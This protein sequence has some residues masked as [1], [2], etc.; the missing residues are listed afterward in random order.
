MAKNET[1]TMSMR[2]IDRLKVIQAVVDRNLKPMQAA[3]RLGLTTRQVRRMVSRYRDDGPA[4]RNRRC[5][6]NKGW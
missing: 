6:T 1:I 2:E 5:A 4:S 3:Q